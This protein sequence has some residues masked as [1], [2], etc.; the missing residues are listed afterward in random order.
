MSVN[1]LFAALAALAFVATQA[2]AQ[3]EKGYIFAT[4]PAAQQVSGD[5]LAQAKALLPNMAQGSEL[6]IRD[7]ETDAKGVRHIAVNQYISGVKQDEALL[8]LHVRDGKLIALNGQVT[9]GDSHNQVNAR[10]A[11]HSAVLTAADAMRK[12]GVDGDADRATLVDVMIKG[13][14]RTVY[15]KQTGINI[16]YIDAYTGELLQKESALRNAVD[17]EGEGKDVTGKAGTFYLGE[18]DMTSVQLD[19]GKYVL[20]DNGRKIYTYDASKYVLTV[21]SLDLN[22]SRNFEVFYK[23]CQDF[24]NYSNDW[25]DIPYTIGNMGFNVISVGANFWDKV[26]V[27]I[28]QPTPADEN[29]KCVPLT[30]TKKEIPGPDGEGAFGMRLVNADIAFN[31]PLLLALN[32]PYWAAIMYESYGTTSVQGIFELKTLADNN[33]IST[34]SEV[35]TVIQKNTIVGC[36]PALDAHW[37]L[38]KIYDFYKTELNRD[39]YDNKGGAIRA[40]FNI[41]DQMLGPDMHANACALHL[42]NG[43][44][45]MCYGSGYPDRKPCVTIDLAGHEFTH[46]VAKDLRNRNESG[47]L[48]EG[49]A[50]IMG[51][52]IKSYVTGEECWSWAKGMSFYSAEAAIRNLDDPHQDEHPNYYLTDEYY[53]N[54]AEG[55]KPDGNNDNGGVHVNSSIVSHWYYLL[56]KGEKGVTAIDKMDALKIAYYTLIGYQFPNMTYPYARKSSVLE[57]SILF[58]EDSQQVKSVKAAWDAVGV[59]ADG[60]PTGI[61]TPSVANS[62]KRTS[63]KY[64]VQGVKVSDDY[65]GIVVSDGAARLQK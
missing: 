56:C 7:E 59:F 15:K 51:V 38:Q 4:I 65:R 24:T 11:K 36:Q 29:V 6:V 60:D 13:K 39:S 17:D 18:Q 3:D 5:L 8:R 42:E 52:T 47:A 50:D 53:K 46:L 19:N 54:L 57:A 64:N 44:G 61:G 34:D 23:Y 9:T 62:S 28:Y 49:F 33:D 43:E 37:G 27:K 45:V 30:M 26:Y 48:D 40:Y 2:T 21:D 32:K 14:M 58:G 35:A 25:L 12:A 1:K 31:E 20:H 41:S 55:E 63:S 10:K 22:E 16:C